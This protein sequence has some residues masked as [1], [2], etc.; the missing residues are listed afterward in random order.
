MKF[1]AYTCFLFS[2]AFA[3][4]GVIAKYVF[5]DEVPTPTKHLIDT[6]GIP[7]ELAIYIT[8]S[9]TNVDLGV[10]CINVKQLPRGDIMVIFA[11]SDWQHDRQKDIDTYVKDGYKIIIYD[12]Y[13]NQIFLCK[14]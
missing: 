1:L 7:A 3:V 8:F 11:K 9:T 10:C 14:S 13:N 4:L 2:F 6:Y 5:N 12:N